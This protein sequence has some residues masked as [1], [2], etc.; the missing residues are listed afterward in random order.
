MAL[1]DATLGVACFGALG[2]TLPYCVSELKVL[3]H[4][5]VGF[6]APSPPLPVLATSAAVVFAA[7]VVFEFGAKKLMD[8]SQALAPG[9]LLAKAR[10]RSVLA[11]HAMDALALGYLGYLGA[12][13]ASAPGFLESIPATAYERVYAYSPRFQY[14]CVCMFAFQAKN[15]LDSLRWGDGPEFI[16]HHSI[17]LFVGWGGLHPFLHTYG[18]FFFGISEISTAALAVLAAFD[19]GGHGVVALEEG[20]PNLKVAVGCLFMVSFVA[21]RVVAWPFFAYHLTSDLLQVL[22]HGQAHSV[23]VCYAN[24]GGLLALTLLQFYWLT[25]IVA[26]AKVELATF[27]TPAPGPAAAH[28]HLKSS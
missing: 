7:A 4:F 9:V 13:M 2:F 3:P 14:L 5:E 8:A 23:F 28:E 6:P 20:F 26:R 11:R 27:L 18:T 10:D 24:L 21:I 19:G 17:T 25:E 22:A 1:K 15:M 16:M 12:S